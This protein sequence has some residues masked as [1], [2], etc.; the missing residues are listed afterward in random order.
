MSK[1]A[2]S[3]WRYQRRQAGCGITSACEEG[4]SYEVF[5]FAV[6]SP[7]PPF[8]FG[9]CAA[10]VSNEGGEDHARLFA[11]APD[12]LEALEGSRVIMETAPCFCSGAFCCT[13]CQTIEEANTAIDK[14]KGQKP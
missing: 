12:M 4:I 8:A 9:A 11:A 14:A 2:V 13:R 7:H 10:L 6:Y 5:P 1:R 3:E